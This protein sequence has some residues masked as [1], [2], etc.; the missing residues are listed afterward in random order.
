MLE[1]RNLEKRFG[2]LIA[3]A[4]VSL[5]IP[6]GAIFG[7]IGPNGAGK[8]TLFNVISGIE[9]PQHGK[10]FLLEEEITAFSMPTIARKGL[11]RT[12]QRSMPFAGMTALENLLVA[13]Y[14]SDDAK[15]RNVASR[16]LGIGARLDEIEAR[17]HQL[18]ALAGLERMADHM[19]ET[20]SH[21]DLRRLEVARALMIR[22]R[23]LLL[24]EPAAGLSAD[25]LGK[26]TT[27]LRTVRAG[28][29]TIVIIE[30]NMTLMMNI[31]DR[32]AVL[33]HCAKFAEGTPAEIQNHEAVVE[34][35]FG[36]ENRNA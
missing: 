28:D 22:P 29:T 30:H 10:V 27:L 3:L 34:A 2:G 6:R 32:I 9:S 26:I 4:G 31:C 7:I 25:E 35:Y 36:H 18:L 5:E 21:G 24:D 20:L 11:A 33:D 19:A 23:V 1:V 13:G 15:V 8:T 12:F 16:W 17:S 14:A